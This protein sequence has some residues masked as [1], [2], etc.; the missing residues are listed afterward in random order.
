MAWTFDA[1]TLPVLLRGVRLQLEELHAEREREL[2]AVRA[3]YAPRIEELQNVLLKLDASTTVAPAAPVSNYRGHRWE[4]LVEYLQH[5]SAPTVNALATML[6]GGDNGVSRNRVRSL[7]NSY[8]TKGILKI[9]DDGRME[10][11][12]DVSPPRTALGEAIYAAARV[13][14]EGLGVEDLV[15]LVRLQPGKENTPVVAVQGA[16]GTLIHQGRLRVSGP[17][18]RRLYVAV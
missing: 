12:T 2:D 10:V 11:C 8:Q 13:N 16:L 9:H 5:D 3:R 18:A 1:E 17:R 14:P 7:L 6:Y 15:R 4:Q